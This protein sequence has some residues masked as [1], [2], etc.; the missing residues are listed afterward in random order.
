MPQYRPAGPGYYTPF[1]QNSTV[2]G[3]DLPT[4]VHNLIRAMKGIQ[5]SLRLWSCHQ[6]TLEHVSNCYMQFGVQFNIIVQAFE[7]YDITTSDLHAIP[8]RLRTTLEDCLGDSPNAMDQYMPEVRQL[9][10]ELL[11]G[12]RSK[13]YAW[14]NVSG[15]Q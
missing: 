7:G 11:Q 15:R 14:R 9:L 6:A 1:P 10:C 2:D 3:G 12:L 13:Q 5:E 8:A 4:A